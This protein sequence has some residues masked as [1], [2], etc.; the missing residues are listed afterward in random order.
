MSRALGEGPQVTAQILEEMEHES[1]PLH[2]EG[3]DV[4]EAI[5]RTDRVSRAD[6]E[7]LTLLLRGGRLD[8]CPQTRL[9]PVSALSDLLLSRHMKYLSAP[10]QREFEVVTDQEGVFVDC[11]VLPVGGYRLRGE[12]I[13][14]FQSLVHDFPLRTNPP[15][16]RGS[17]LRLPVL[18]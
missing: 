8:K 5:G 1:A 14:L 12:S 11:S 15:L 9:I 17:S 2:H 4:F 3:A 10:R 7:K 13:V 6:E 16:P 18:R